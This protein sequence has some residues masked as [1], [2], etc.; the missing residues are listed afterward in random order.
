MIDLVCI[1]MQYFC[2]VVRTTGVN[3][4]V[5]LKNIFGKIIYDIQTRRLIDI[6]KCTPKKKQ[7]N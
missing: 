6:G 4:I 3:L 2:D 7:I 5:T 1:H